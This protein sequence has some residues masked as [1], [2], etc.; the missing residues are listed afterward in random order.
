MLDNFYTIC[1]RWDAW[2]GKTER[3][4]TMP[5]E[6]TPDCSGKPTGT[7][8]WNGKQGAAQSRSLKRAVQK[9]KNSK[10]HSYKS[11][12]TNYFCVFPK[13]FLCGFRLASDWLLC[14]F[15]YFFATLLPLARLRMVRLAVFIP[16]ST[17][18]LPHTLG[19]IRIP[20]K[21]QLK[22]NKNVFI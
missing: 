11:F 18:V 10:K 8:T 1:E 13:W 22:T 15:C 12:I 14:G 7:R 20:P 2:E 17:L 6:I 21:I 16:Y 9:R 5:C 3:R 19:F 4:R